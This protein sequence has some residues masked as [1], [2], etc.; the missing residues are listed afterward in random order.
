MRYCQQCGTPNQDNA[1]YCTRCGAPLAPVMGQQGYQQPYQQPAYQQPYQ[2]PPYVKMGFKDAIRVCM[3]EKYASFEGRATRSEYW[4]FYLFY[5]ICAFV[6]VFAVAILGGIIG[7]ATEEFG[8]FIAIYYIGVLL[9]CLPFM[10]P[11]ISVTVRRLHD[12]GRS[13]WWFW[14]GFVPLLGGIILL[15]LM[16]LESQPRDNEFGRY[17]IN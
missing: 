16:I 6:G 2:Q 5:A 7:Y 1:T 9:I 17:V 12:T 10:I 11:F 15:V 14:I 13:G 4:L 3:K 8:V